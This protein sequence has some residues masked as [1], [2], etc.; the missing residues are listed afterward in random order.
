MPISVFSLLACKVNQFFGIY[1]HKEDNNIG[2]FFLLIMGKLVSKK[3]IPTAIFCHWK[4]Q[5]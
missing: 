5:K 3:I 1:R 2:N 4:F